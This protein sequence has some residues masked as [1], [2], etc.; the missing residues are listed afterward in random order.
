MKIIDIGVNL[1]HRSFN[2]DRESIVEDARFEGVSPLILTGTSEKGSI[3]SVKYASRF[4]N[5]LYSTVGVHP[6]DAKSCN[7]KTIAVL[8]QLAKEECVV[9]VG[10]CG[11]D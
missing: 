11:L 1:M 7:D 9:A 8:K 3:E 2:V 6:H 5:Q 10:E 4:R